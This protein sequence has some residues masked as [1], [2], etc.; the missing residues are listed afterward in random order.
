[1][2]IK[3]EIQSS[4]GGSWPTSSGALIGTKSATHEGACTSGQRVNP[5]CP[6]EAIELISQHTQQIGHVAV[7][8]TVGRIRPSREVL[9]G[10]VR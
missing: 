5:A 8:F 4:D 1:V 9:K 6:S 2:T 10:T 7:T 3:K